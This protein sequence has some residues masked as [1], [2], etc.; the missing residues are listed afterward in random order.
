[1]RDVFGDKDWKHI[2]IVVANIN[3]DFLAPV[4]FSDD[5]V[6]GTS[7]WLVADVDETGKRCEQ[8]LCAVEPGDEFA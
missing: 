7:L 5:L 2:G 8:F 1:M 3:A 4:F 6:M